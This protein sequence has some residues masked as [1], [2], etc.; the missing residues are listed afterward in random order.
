MEMCGAQFWDLRKEKAAANE[1]EAA[2]NT[3]PAAK[4]T[5]TAPELVATTCLA[6]IVKPHQMS[7]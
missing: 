4:T 6:S 5:A 2:A 3:G 7:T 1:I